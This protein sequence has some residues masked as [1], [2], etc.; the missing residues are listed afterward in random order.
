[1]PTSLRRTA[2]WLGEAATGG[3]RA[4]ARPAVRPTLRAA[5]P[6]RG[7]GG[8][9]WRLGLGLS[10]AALAAL[11]VAVPALYL[12][13]VPAW[14][15][16]GAMLRAELADPAATPWHL[17]PHPVPNALA[18]ALAAA[19]L[20]VL[21]P[22]ATGAALALA[23]LIGGG[24]AAW[25][26]ARAA[27]PGAPG[28]A[29]ARAAVLVSCLVV[30]SS[31][32]NGYVGFQLGVALAF[33][34]GA[35]WLR[36]GRLGPA[37]TLAASLALFAAHAVPFGALALAL[38]LSALRRRDAAEL[39]ALVPAGALALWYAA[40]RLAG[41]E[42]FVPAAETGGLARA[43]AYKGYTVLKL[44][45][46]QR[47]VGLDGAP[48]GQGPGLWIALGLSAVFVAALGVAL[49]RGTAAMAPGGRRRAAAFAWGL[50]GVALVMPPFA[51][52]VVNPGERLLV[53]AAGALVALVPLDDRWARVFGVAALLFVADDAAGLWAQR[54][55]LA[56]EARAAA[57]AD[58]AAR[59]AAARGRGPAAPA[60]GDAA[61]EAA[62]APAD[63]LLVHAVLLHS[64]LY[65]A[66]ARRDWSRETFDSGLLVRA[67]A[68][69]P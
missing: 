35:L 7:R 45:P 55:G 37:W 67:D 57:Y 58:R 42:A 19:L 18:H 44:G 62:A 11:V 46:L 49:V 43:L 24:A 64:D 40:A 39:A 29:G 60:F 23:M 9:A 13:D 63:R 66:A 2:R 31:W 12:T 10:L 26:L 59:E 69:E 32:W 15:F 54:R 22:Q 33:A 52:N 14:V 50:A 5:A 4:A 17:A 20:G 61:R 56:P 36:R 68:A 51:L 28:Q 48:P 25:A 27:W 53:L 47:P 3:T 30:S 34:T 16:G 1:M 38:G 6:E 41:P 65:D 8:G 21:S